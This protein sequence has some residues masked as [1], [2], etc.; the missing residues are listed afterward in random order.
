MSDQPLLWDAIDLPEWV[1]TSQSYLQTSLPLFTAMY[2]TWSLPRV[3][4]GHWEAFL[5]FF[6]PVANHCPLHPVKCDGLTDAHAA[7][8]ARSWIRMGSLMKALCAVLMQRVRVIW[9]AH[10]CAH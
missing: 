7:E 6:E 8:A 5:S 10:E 9:L 3:V 1:T 2:T 4:P